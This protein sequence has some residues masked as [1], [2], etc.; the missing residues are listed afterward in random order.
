MRTPNYA[1]VA[2]FAVNMKF[3]KFLLQTVYC[4]TYSYL[5]YMNVAIV[6]TKIS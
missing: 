3:R 1:T 4:L 5:I 6:R 2:S